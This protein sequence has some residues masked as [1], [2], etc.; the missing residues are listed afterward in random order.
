VRSAPRLSSVG[1]LLI[2]VGALCAVA[3]AWSMQASAGAPSTTVEKHI[4]YAVGGT[5]RQTLD[6]YQPEGEDR[7]RPAV[8]MVHGGGFAGGSPDD[9]ARQARLAA[10]QGWVVF[11]LDYRTTSDLGTT[12]DA[13]P[14]ELDDV[15]AGLAWVRTHALDHGADP[16]TISILGSSA[17]GALAALAAA[18]RSSGVRVAA[19]WSAPTELAGLVPADDGVPP[20]CGQNNQCVQFWQGPWLT[21]LLGCT[22]EVCP[23]RYAEASPVTHAARMPPTFLANG[24]EEIVPLDQ[25]E[26]MAAALSDH[27]T[28]TELREVPGARHGHTATEVVWNDTM[29]FLA[30]GLGVPEPEP[31]EFEDSFDFGWATLAVLLAVIGII[32]AVVARIVRDR[33]PRGVG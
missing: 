32:V 8:V 21:D 13:W 20:A 16:R 25:A 24:T 1:R 29:A 30:R 14:T 23:E 17:G 15:R 10:Q 9:L 19:L 2:V 22:P 18:D 12:G 26:V 33:T 27:D 4:P 31:I 11:N 7:L 3:G 6:I 28:T 5:G